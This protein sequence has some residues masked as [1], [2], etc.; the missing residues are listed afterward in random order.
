M[1]ALHAFFTNNCKLDVVDANYS[2]N[3]HWWQHKID[4]FSFGV[5]QLYSND[6]AIEESA[7]LDEIKRKMQS[8]GNPSLSL[9]S[10]SSPSVESVE[11]MLGDADLDDNA[12]EM[13]NNTDPNIDIYRQGVGLAGTNAGNLMGVIE[14]PKFAVWTIEMVVVKRKPDREEGQG[15]PA[16]WVTVKLGTALKNVSE[17]KVIRNV[18]DEETGEIRHEIKHT[19][20]CKDLAYKFEF[21]SSSTNEDEHF[22]IERGLYYQKSMEPLE[23]TDIETGRVLSDYVKQVRIEEK[24]GKLRS[25][26]LITELISAEETD[27]D[28]WDS[29]A[30]FG[31]FQ[32]SGGVTASKRSGVVMGANATVGKR[33]RDAGGA[34]QSSR[35]P[36]DVFVALVKE[37]LEKLRDEALAEEIKKGIAVIKE[38]DIYV[39]PKRKMGMTKKQS[40]EF[41]LSES[42]R[43]FLIRKREKYQQKIE[44]SK[45][46]INM[47]IEI[48]DHG[49]QVSRDTLRP[50]SSAPFLVRAAPSV[51]PRPSLLTRRLFA[52]GVGAHDGAQV[53]HQV[54]REWDKAADR[55]RDY[56]D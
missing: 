33:C 38:E 55:A 50:S 46:M 3:I 15:D 54:D 4:E 45:K 8:M 14:L 28:Y 10:L 41:N 40:G 52:A 34:G 51:T 37:E 30:L 22:W 26:N 1:E 20:R 19:I 32:K 56:E 49:T 5:D 11:S 2:G 44:E 35:Y 48:F 25:S 13:M 24:Q 16:D 21:A 6:E 9:G 47:N 42:K 43:K 12:Q 31:I 17:V 53:R 39:A 29:G 23:V 27:S 7:K 18:V 36:K